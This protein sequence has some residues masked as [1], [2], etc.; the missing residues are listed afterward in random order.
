[1]SDVFKN[2]CVVTWSFP[3]NDGGAPITGY[4]LERRVAGGRWTRVNTEALTEL[5][6]PFSDL[7]ENSK[8]EFRVAAEN[9]AGI[10]EFSQPSKPIVAK[11]PWE[12][13]GK[14]GIPNA[15]DIK[16]F[17]LNLTWNAPESDGGA[18]ITNYFIEFCVSGSKAWNRYEDQ[19]NSTTTR[20]IKGLKENTSY[21]FKVAAENV[22]GMG[23]FSDPSQPVKTLIGSV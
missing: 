1:M 6:F 20:S 19:P 4:H 12:K 17:T 14:P 16:G 5:K 15:A 18:P 23:P 9:K 11:D 3:N 8:Y 13:P 22:A 21:Q 2:A 7:I 10:G